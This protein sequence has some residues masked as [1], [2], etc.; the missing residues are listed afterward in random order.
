[1]S[2]KIALIQMNPK[3]GDIE[4]NADSIIKSVNDAKKNHKADLVVFPELSLVGYPPDDL[5][6]RNEL[7]DRVELALQSICHSIPDINVI[8]G[9]PRKLGQQKYNA[10]VVIKNQKVVAWYYKHCF[11]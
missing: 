7:F 9:L 1:M 11:W 10:A 8:L 5:L 6:L 3:V 2:C 4:A